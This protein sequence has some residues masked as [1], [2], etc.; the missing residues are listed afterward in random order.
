MPKL[1]LSQLDLALAIAG[2]VV[3]LIGIASKKLKSSPFQESILA[4]LAGVLVGPYA[5]G[6]LDIA[7][8]GAEEPHILEQAARFTLAIGLMGVALRLDKDGLRRLA[9]P[10]GVLLTLGMIGM[11]LASSALAVWLLGLSVW[12]ALL[13]G[14]CITPTDPVVASSIVTGDFARKHLPE[15]VRD[16]ISAESGA[17]DGLAYAFVLAPMVVLQNDETPWRTYLVD[18]ILVGLGVAILVGV[19]VGYVASQLLRV[20]RRRNWIE[21]HSLL[22]YTVALSLATLGLAALL[23]ADA[24]ISVF[25]AGLVFNLRSD[26]EEQHRE[27]NIQEAVNKLFTLPMFVILGI[28]LPIEAWLESGWPLLTF[29]ILVLFLRRPPAVAV[30]TPALRDPLTT[31]DVAFVGWFGPVG[32][33]AIYYSAYAWRH[34]EDPGAWHATSAVVVASILLHGGTTSTLSRLYARG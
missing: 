23:R 9:R 28:A 2:V 24:L 21:T 8:W 25:L 34:L 10:V 18:H 12:T 33:A 31:R 22:S 11:W 15:R 6:L 27:E 29:A 1:D 13:L 3:I 5:L 30:M 4:L 32:V 16:T 7:R 26:V 20:A 17:N 19:A 14:A